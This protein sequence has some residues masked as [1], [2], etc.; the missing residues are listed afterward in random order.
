MAN[1]QDVVNAFYEGVC[2]VL[3]RHIEMQDDPLDGIDRDELADYVR[4]QPGFYPSI[5][6]YLRHNT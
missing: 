2:L 5:E 4:A 3:E 1:K 6:N